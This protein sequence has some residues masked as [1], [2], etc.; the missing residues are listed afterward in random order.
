VKLLRFNIKN[1]EFKIARLGP[2]EGREDAGKEGSESTFVNFRQL[3]QEGDMKAL[4][5]DITGK[6][7]HTAVVPPE[8]GRGGVLSISALFTRRYGGRR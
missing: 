8:A 4:S 5:V 3:F 2:P 1:S 7:E 6:D